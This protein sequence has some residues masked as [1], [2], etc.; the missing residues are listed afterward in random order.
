MPKARRGGAIPRS[1]SDPKGPR[2]L[3]ARDR[4]L[5]ALDLRKA[6]MSYSQIGNALGMTK[7]GASQ[8]VSSILKSTAQE[9]ADEVRKLEVERLDTLLRGVWPRAIQG[10]VHAVD[11][12]LRIIE[13]RSA[14]LGLDAPVKTEHSGDPIVTSNVQNNVNV[15]A[16]L[17]PLTQERLV[18]MLGLI[19]KH[20]LMEWMKPRM[21]ASAI[22]I[23]QEQQQQKQEG[24]TDGTGQVERP[25]GA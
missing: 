4:A 25:A 1:A 19:Q 3:K 2:R 18:E 12:C 10:D 9:P 7:M 17:P 23:Q 6:G 16:E 20:G 8:A 14:I 13:R 5:Q 22:E 11:R 24:A 15:K 21:E